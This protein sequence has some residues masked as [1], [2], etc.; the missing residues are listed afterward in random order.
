[1]AQDAPAAAPD[2]PNAGQDA[3]AD[4]RLAR[5][6]KPSNAVEYA[7]SNDK[8]R[9]D[10]MTILNPDCSSIGKISVRIIKKP[11]HGDLTFTPEE[12]FSDFKETNIR[13]HCNVNKVRGVSVYY[14]SADQF[15]GEDKATVLFLY[16][17]ASADVMDYDI[18]VR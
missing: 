5:L 10:F 15:V 1:M 2:T 4:D 14:Q 12:G 9:F 7:A 18:I 8:V 11:E 16:P 13:S 17:D 6:P 3:V